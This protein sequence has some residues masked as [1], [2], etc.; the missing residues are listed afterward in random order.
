MREEDFKAGMNAVL[1]ASLRVRQCRALEDGFPALIVAGWRGRAISSASFHRRERPRGG[2]FDAFMALASYTAAR[3]TKS[4]ENAC[5]IVLSCSEARLKRRRRGG[6]SRWRRPPP[7]PGPSSRPFGLSACARLRAR[8]SHAHH[9]SH[10]YSGADEIGR[11]C[12]HGGGLKG[13]EQPLRL[14]VN[15]T[16]PR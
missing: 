12:L 13:M 14:I 5:D 6:K 11:T 4:G 2:G 16:R 8:G 1:P 15:G 7:P 3:R 9:L 10:G